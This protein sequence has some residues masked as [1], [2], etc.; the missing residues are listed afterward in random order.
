MS[1]ETKVESF[2]PSVDLPN[3][4][5]ICAEEVKAPG[6]SIG[7]QMAIAS[8]G[9]I[10]DRAIEIQDEVILEELAH[11]GLVEKGKESNV[12]LSDDSTS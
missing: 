7:F 2:R 4:L 5:L 6:I 12:D 8:F 11:I 3:L 9:R 1:E 10:V